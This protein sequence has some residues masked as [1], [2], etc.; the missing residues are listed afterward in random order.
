VAWPIVLAGDLQA[1]S[2]LTAMSVSAA[3]SDI[4]PFST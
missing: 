2:L 3:V 1:T 4:S